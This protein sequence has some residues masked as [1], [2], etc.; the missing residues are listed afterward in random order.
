MTNDTTAT[1]PEVAEAATQSITL[2]KD[3]LTLL[4][5]FGKS[6]SRKALVRTE[7]GSIRK[8]ALGDRIGRATVTAVDESAVHLVQGDLSRK[9]SM[10]AELPGVPP[11]IRPLARP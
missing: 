11:R 8:V 2:P 6:E 4:G 7:S 10:P 5:T 1:A 9:L 3:R